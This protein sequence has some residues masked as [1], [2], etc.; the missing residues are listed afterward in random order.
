[1]KITRSQTLSL[2]VTTIVLLNCICHVT[3][4]EPFST[5][6]LIAYGVTALGGAFYSDK[7]KSVTYC[8]LDKVECCIDEQIPHRIYELRDLLNRKLYGQHIVIEK[9]SNAIS[10]HF[11][12]IKD[13]RKPLVM[14]FHGT[15]GVGKNYVANMIADVLYKKGTSSEYFHVF[16]GSQYSDEGRVEYYKKMIK[17]QIFKGI[18][19]CEYSMFV[20]DEVDKM[21]RGVFNSITAMLDHHTLVN[22]RNFRKAIFIFLTNYGGDGITKVVHDKINNQKIYRHEITLVDLEAVAM[23]E[24]YNGGG[25]DDGG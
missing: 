24:T 8:K 7:I 19:T 1:M 18:D 4:F 11:K 16:H 25:L 13:S 2:V 22:G 9:V 5:A 23:K 10:S 20:F 3:A 15:P 6:Y 17:E 12:T 14:S 21:P